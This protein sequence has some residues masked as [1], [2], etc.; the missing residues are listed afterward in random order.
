MLIKSSL[1]CDILSISQYTL[2]SRKNKGIIKPSYNDGVDDYYDTN[3]LLMFDEI[4]SMHNSNW[5][6]FISIKP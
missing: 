1:L 5:N 4:S 6:E 2:S 3:D